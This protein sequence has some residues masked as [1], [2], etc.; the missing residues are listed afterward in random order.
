VELPGETLDDE[1]LRKRDERAEQVYARRTEG[2]PAETAAVVAVQIAEA[3][4]DA[5][6]Q[7]VGG[8]NAAAAVPLTGG[9]ENEDDGH[10][11][12]E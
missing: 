8:K 9:D 3:I 12:G 6:A 4:R 2:A 11:K 10:D 7:Q 1:P 5:D